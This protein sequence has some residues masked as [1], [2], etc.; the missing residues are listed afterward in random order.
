VISDRGLCWFSDSSTLLFS[1][2]RDESL[3]NTTEAQVRGNTS[4]GIG[5]AR[6]N[7]FI[8]GLFLF[9]IGTG[10]IRQFANG[11]YPALAIDSGQFIVRDE[12]GLN[13]LDAQGVRQ[14]RIDIPRLAF[15]PAVISP[16]GRLIL[17]T[18]RRNFSLYPGGRLTVVD[19]SKPSLR[20]ILADDLVYKCKWIRTEQEGP[21]NG[22]PS[23]R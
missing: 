11:D 16:D 9:N 5:Y 23:V 14:T 10:E 22:V 3:Y 13:V 12:D 6:D 19:L 21:T 17:A 1:S 18:I 2:F 20:H 15:S 8:R 4:Y 7:K